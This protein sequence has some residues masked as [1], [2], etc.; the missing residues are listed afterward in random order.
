[1]LDFSKQKGSF[2][3]K[4]KELHQKHNEAVCQLCERESEAEAEFQRRQ[5]IECEVSRLQTIVQ[6]LHMDNEKLQNHIQE[7]KTIAEKLQ[8]DKVKHCEEMRK[9]VTTLIEIKTEL[10]CVCD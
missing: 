3:A 1:M 10:T 7:W 9:I 5:M 8:S 6:Q 4:I 2:I